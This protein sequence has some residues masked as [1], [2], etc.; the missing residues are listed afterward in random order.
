MNFDLGKGNDF[1]ELTYD[2]SSAHAQ[3]GTVQ[4]CILA[5]GQFGMEPRAYIQEA[6]QAAADLRVLPTVGLVTLD[7][8]FIRVLLPAPLR[9]RIPITSP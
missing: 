2:V 3:D 1:V 7:R 6:S 8:I 5:S 4:E 9:P